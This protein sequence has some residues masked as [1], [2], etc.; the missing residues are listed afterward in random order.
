MKREKTMNI[1]GNWEDFLPNET[2]ELA[3]KLYEKTQQERN[4]G[5]ILYPPQ[6]LIFR[7]FNGINPE[8]VK[9]VIVGQD[10]Y[11][12]EGQANGLSFSVNKGC[13]LPPSLQNIY[14]EL[15]IEFGW[16][17]SPEHGDLTAWEKQGVLLL[18]STL[19]YLVSRKLPPQ[20]VQRNRHRIYFFILKV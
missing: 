18:N 12:E 13:K 14:R 16:E 8:D 4:N 3:K 1:L 7:A 5:R 6:D 9:V 19:T 15:A 2:I 10:P 17:T 20:G 11:H